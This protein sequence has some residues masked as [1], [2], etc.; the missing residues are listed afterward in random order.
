MAHGLVT[1]GVSFPDSTTQTTAAAIT[2]VGAVMIAMPNTA[3]PSGWMQADTA[4][5][6]TTYAALYSV[7]GDVYNSSQMV[8]L[9]Q[10][11]G[12]SIATMQGWVP[13]P[14][15]YTGSKFATNGGSVYIM[16]GD[17]GRVYRSTNAGATWA[18]TVPVN[19]T[20]CFGV[21]YGNGRFVI[22][23]TSK[24]IYSTD[25][26]ASWTAGSMTAATGYNALYGNGVWVLGCSA[27]IIQRSTDG[28][29]F[30]TAQDTGA[31][32]H[33]AGD[34]GNGYFVLGGTDGQVWTSTNG[35]T[36]TQ[37]FADLSA[38]GGT[39]E[40]INDLR[41][42]GGRWFGVAE[43]GIIFYTRDGN[44]TNATGQ[45]WLIQ[46]IAYTGSTVAY[47][48]QTCCYIDPLG[49]YIFLDAANNEGV[50]TYDF[51]QF[52]AL[53]GSFGVDSNTTITYQHVYYDSVNNVFLFN[54]NYV[55]GVDGYGVPNAWAPWLYRN[56]NIASIE[57]T[58]PATH[59]WVSRNYANSG[60]Y[61]GASAKVF[62]KF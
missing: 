14:V 58:P 39:T 10:S 47:D 16:I 30:T 55:T 51:N 18:V 24:L 3:T 11:W 19:A 8:P 13:Q 12:S 59:F 26:G 7:I 62:V 42:A 6:K 54:S 40:N 56:T 37:Q 4:R 60:T 49:I 1:T 2:P 23:G 31:Q 50:W 28:V 45:G 29:T 57:S 21:G 22:T 5:S 27:G 9:S 32:G 46:P 41:Y 44:P 48:Y 61:F 35:S 36:W 43:N 15:Q 38:A 53:P 20:D 25:D 17:A 34:F 52:F 33:L